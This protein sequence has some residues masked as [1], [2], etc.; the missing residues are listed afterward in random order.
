M[1]LTTVI[2][3][4]NEERNIKECLESVKFS[5]EIIVLDDYSNDRT[6]EIAKNFNVRIVRRNLN[7][8]FSAQRNYGLSLAKGDFILFLDAD[9]RISNDLKNEIV[10]FINNPLKTYDGYTL[11]RK[12]VIWN[13]E[14]NFGENG[15]T[16]LLRLAK[17]KAGLWKRKVHEVWSI[18]GNTYTFKNPLYHYPHPNLREYVSEINRY[19]QL[20]AEANL[21]EKKKSSIFKII[22]Y[23]ILKFVN[24]YIIKLGFL[25]GIYGFIVALLMSVH[26][27][28]AWSKL[29]IMQKEK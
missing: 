17:K 21:K 19:S 10:Y 15:R 14:F 22:H 2:L 6:V 4:K 5:D 25:D 23:P 29:W 26:S 18:K 28:L 11:K 7:G 8:D 3:T 16:K 20:H 13:H 12:D 1:K 24:T 9:E 27:Y